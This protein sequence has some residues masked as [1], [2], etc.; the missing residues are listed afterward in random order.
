ME[1]SGNSESDM[2]EIKATVREIEEVLAAQPEVLYYLSGVGAVISRYDYFAQ[3]KGQGN[4]VGDFFIRVDLR[5]G[6]RFKKTSDFVEYLQ[7]ELDAQVAGGLITV[8]ELG[9]MFL[10]CKSVEIKLY[11]EDLND[12]N[13]AANLVVR[14]MQEG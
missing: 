3:P 6:R 13:S 2:Q 14:A 9:V 7:K 4:N 5:Q 11:G 1:L 8:D 10:V 12:L